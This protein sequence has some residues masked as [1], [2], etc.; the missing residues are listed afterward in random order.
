MTVDETLSCTCDAVVCQGP[1]LMA[2]DF[3]YRHELPSTTKVEKRRRSDEAGTVLQILIRLVS[4][5]AG[6]V[7]V[8][9]DVAAE[10]DELDIERADLQER[11]MWLV[12]REYL[13]LDGHVDGVARLWVNPAV[14]FLPR[15][16]DPRVAAAR[17]RFPYIVT[18]EE[19]MAADPPFHVAEYDK[20]GWER[21]Y[22]DNR[23]QIEDPPRF[24]FGCPSHH[25]TG[26]Y[27]L[28]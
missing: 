18:D 16:T 5:L 24:S 27:P 20:E 2:A 17:H 1:A 23:E 8:V 12:D 10:A 6:D 22:E 4:R 7:P 21:V 3:Q 15:T 19:G 14:A 11:L 25:N 9:L 28:A 13:A 26:P